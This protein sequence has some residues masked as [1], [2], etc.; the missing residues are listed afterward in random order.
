M[1]PRSLHSV[2][3]D[4]LSTL[5]QFIDSSRFVCETA[6]SSSCWPSS[7]RLQGF[8]VSSTSCELQLDFQLLSSVEALHFNE[9]SAHP[10]LLFFVTVARTLSL[11]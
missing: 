3:T 8:G 6:S 5:P 4:E 11:P 7:F 9:L 10:F 2:V 1:A